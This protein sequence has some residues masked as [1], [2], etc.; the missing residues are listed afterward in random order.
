M[1]VG[2]WALGTYDGD[3]TTMGVGVFALHRWARGVGAAVLAETTGERELPVG[4]AV[5]AY[6]TSRLGLG[7]SVLRSWGPVFLDAGIFPEL[8]LLT[9]HGK[10]LTIARSVTTW[11]AA[12][13]MRVRLG[14]S[15]G[16]IAPFLFL[17]GCG[18]LRAQNLT[19]EGNPASRTLSRWTVNAGVG[20]SF[21][22]GD[23]K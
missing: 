20:L 17:S 5:A 2:A 14:L 12:L 3:A 10:Q 19:L 18:A 11:D 21:R 23:S 8:T 9:V 7:A 15:A 22:F 4:P 13:D 16:R 6:R 1:E